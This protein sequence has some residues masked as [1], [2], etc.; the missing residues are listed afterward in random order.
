[1]FPPKIIVRAYLIV[2]GGARRRSFGLGVRNSY[3]WENAKM[4]AASIRPAAPTRTDTDSYCR[5]GGVGESLLV[6]FWAA[7]KVWC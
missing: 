2:C 6:W 3:L 4:A 1:M 7:L 5:P